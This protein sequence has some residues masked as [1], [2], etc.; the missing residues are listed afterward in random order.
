MFF[1]FSISKRKLAFIAMIAL[2]AVLIVFLAA[3]EKATLKACQNVKTNVHEQ[4]N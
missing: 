3:N 1:K 4:K 2:A